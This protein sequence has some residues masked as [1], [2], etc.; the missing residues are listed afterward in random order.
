MPFIVSENH[1]EYNDE[2]YSSP[3][4]AAGQEP[5][6]PVAIFDTA[7]EAESDR[8]TRELSAWRNTD[9]GGYVYEIREG[10][11][12]EIRE[13]RDDTHGVYGNHNTKLRERKEEYAVIIGVDPLTVEFGYDFELA[14][15]LT[16]EQL[17]KVVKLFGGPHFYNV[18]EV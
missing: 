13:S 12:Y 14:E 3:D 18:F 11:E 10:R 7:V 15:N 17:R 6:V 16:D 8:W 4:A 9:V 5:G 1:F 2:Y